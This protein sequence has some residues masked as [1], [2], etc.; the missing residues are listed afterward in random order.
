MSDSDRSGERGHRASVDRASGE[1]HGAGSGA[2]G[3]DPREDYDSDPAAG[4][5]EARPTSPAAGD[6]AVEADLGKSRNPLPR[7]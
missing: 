2:G 1:V 3:R 5:G 6:R 4:G 7:S